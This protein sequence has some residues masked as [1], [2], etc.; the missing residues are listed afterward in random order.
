MR[1]GH[2]LAGAEGGLMTRVVIIVAGIAVG[3]LLGSLIFVA[4][5]S[6]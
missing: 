1:R 6:F 3:V 4:A 2:D 5:R